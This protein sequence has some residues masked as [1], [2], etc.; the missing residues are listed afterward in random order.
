MN[1]EET[2]LLTRYVKGACPQQ[3]IDELTPNAWHDVLGHLTY[4]DCC[5]AV[6]RV[7]KNQPFVAPAEIIAEVKRLRTERLEG[8]VYVPGSADEDTATYLKRLREQRAAVAAGQRE[9]DPTPQLGSEE[10][11]KAVAEIL[12]AAALPAPPKK[13]RT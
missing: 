13:G 6:A 5:A 8:F 3:H 2:V 4:K 12:A 10:S 11:R 1:R 9:A 7:A